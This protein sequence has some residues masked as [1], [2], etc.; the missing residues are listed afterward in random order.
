[1]TDFDDDEPSPIDVPSST[2][3]LSVL[4]PW[5]PFVDK[6]A[7]A[8]MANAEAVLMAGGK[9]DGQKVVRGR[10][11]RKWTNEM[12]EKEIAEA[13]CGDFGLEYGQLYSDP[14]FLT[15]PQAEKLV[16]K[17]RRKELNEWL[18]VKPEGALTMV[19]EDDKREAVTVDPAD[20][21]DNI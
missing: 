5:V 15:G 8:V 18:L 12:D 16:P 19:P 1:M 14:K 11:T 9:I 17:D 3:H 2:D 20:D 10:S 6:W 7:K 4:V 13:L 21:F